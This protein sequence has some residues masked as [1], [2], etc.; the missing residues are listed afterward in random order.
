VVFLEVDKNFSKSVEQY[1]FRKPQAVSKRIAIID[2][3]KTHAF[4]AILED[5]LFGEWRK[6]PF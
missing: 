4:K 6:Y 2:E 5:R 3:T 1:T